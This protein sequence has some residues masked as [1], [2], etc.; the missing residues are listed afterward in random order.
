MIQFRIAKHT[1]NEGDIVEIWQDD[2]F[3][4]AVYP[5]GH[6]GVRVVSQYLTFNSIFVDT[7]Q[8]IAV[9]LQFAETVGEPIPLRCLACG[10]MLKGALTDH[11]PG[12]EMKA[13]ID[14]A[15]T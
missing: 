1:G 8:P 13:I 3:V 12:C 15:R 7:R 11:K 9:R 5:H 10:A 2:K 6:D 4:G 14:Q